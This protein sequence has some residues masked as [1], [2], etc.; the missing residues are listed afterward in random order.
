MKNLVRVV[1]LA[2]ALGAFGLAT[3][4]PSSTSAVDS[5]SACCEGLEGDMHQ[6]CMHECQ[7]NCKY[8]VCPVCRKGK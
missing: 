3:F 2:L 6:A 7:D 8:H 1:V 4:T 5:C